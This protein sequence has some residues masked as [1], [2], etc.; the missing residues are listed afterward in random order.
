MKSNQVNVNQLISWYIERYPLAREP[1]LDLL[2]S[3]DTYNGIDL[4][5]L[6]DGC[7]RICN[8]SD[9]EITVFDPIDWSTFV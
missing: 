2:H 9:Y 5:L 1:L 7:Q 6:E 4:D 8:P 3:F